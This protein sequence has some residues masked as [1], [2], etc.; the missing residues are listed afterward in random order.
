M[1]KHLHRELSPLPRTCRLP[2][3]RPGHAGAEGGLG[4]PV[5]DSVPRGGLGARVAAALTACS[6]GARC[7]KVV[8]SEMGGTTAPERHCSGSWPAWMALVAKCLKG[9]S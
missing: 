5:G 8:E 9:G 6:P 4:V 2:D 1:G 3:P 7:L